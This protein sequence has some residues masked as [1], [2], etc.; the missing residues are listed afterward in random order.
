M[1]CFQL[2]RSTLFHC[3]SYSSFHSSGSPSSISPYY[4]LNLKLLLLRHT[5]SLVYST[6]SFNHPVSGSISTPHRH[7]PTFCILLWFSACRHA[8]IA[9]AQQILNTT[10]PASPTTM[11]TSR[12]LQLW[13]EL[14]IYPSTI[15]PHPILQLSSFSTRI[16]SCASI[17]FEL[18]VISS[19]LCSRMSYCSP[20]FSSR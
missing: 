13:H 2:L 17:S 1:L 15:N 10:Q 9:T 8:P 4:I 11:T 14:A 16:M 19:L 6:S 7:I 12:S 20:Q 18:H 5:L 3:R